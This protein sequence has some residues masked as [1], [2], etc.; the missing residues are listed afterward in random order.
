MR[1]GVAILASQPMP[2]V[3]RR[4]FRFETRGI[5]VA[6]AAR[7]G[8]VTSSQG[9]R[10]SIV[11]AK[12][13]RGWQK[14]L[15]IVAIF[16]AVDVRGARKLASMGVGVTVRAVL[17]LHRIDRLFA[18]RKMALC[19]LQQCM[20]ALQRIRSGSV[21]F[22]PKRRGFE[23]VGRVAVRTLDSAGALGELSPMRIRLVTVSAFLKCK[24]FLEV[25][26]RMTPHALHIRVLPE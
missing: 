8:D 7:N 24:S 19:T 15:E 22:Y 6:V 26:A 17:K 5:F 14:S 2:V 3:L 20:L 11:S 12:T 13:K 4:W 9:K 16:T 10:S 25:S 23:A 21:C 1:I 18:S